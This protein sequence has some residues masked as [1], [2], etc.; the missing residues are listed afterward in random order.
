MVKGGT[1]FKIMPTLFDTAFDFSSRV[2]LITGGAAGIGR[3]I[4]EAFRERGAA[5]V[6]VD[7]NPAVIEFAASLG[8]GHL[9]YVADVSDEKLCN[10]IVGDAVAKLGRID[11]LI[12]NAGIGI[13]APAEETRTEDWNKTLSINLNGPF[14]Y[15]RRVGRE[16]LRQ[17]YGR[18]VTIASQAAVIGLEHH[19]AYC[20]SKAALLGMTRVLA[21]EWGPHGITANT[22]SPTVVETELALVGWAGEKGEAM[23]KKIPSRRF[24]RPDEIAMAAL[25]LASDAAGMINGDNL[26]VDGGFSN[27]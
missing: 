3:A 19:L 25:Y 26:L 1:L 12:N 18:I 8:E 24:A 22:I 21:L 5:L 4:A 2:T 27:Q 9:G 7:R 13:L 20:T 11:H 10:E 14:L 16:M 6:L 23:K 15:S 17:K